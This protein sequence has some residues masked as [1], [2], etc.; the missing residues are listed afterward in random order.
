M[1]PLSPVFRAAPSAVPD[2]VSDS[3]PVLVPAGAGRAVS[4][5]NRPGWLNLAAAECPSISA[6]HAWQLGYVHRDQECLVA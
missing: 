3:R 2:W 1:V 6:R 5:L 4:G